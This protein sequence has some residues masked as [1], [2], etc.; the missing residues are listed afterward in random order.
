VSQQLQLLVGG[1]DLTPYVEQD[2]W[3]ITQQW[4]RQGD[5]ATFELTDEH[6]VHGALSFVPTP[7]TTVV[8]TDVGLGQTLFSGICEKPEVRFD[9]PTLARWTLDCVDWTYLSDRPS[10]LVVGDYSGYTADALAVLITTQANCG[11]NAATVANGGYV[12]PAVQIP[13]IQFVYDTLTVA[14][15]KL[16]KLASLSTTWGWYVDENRNLHF[17]DLTQAPSA[18]VTL[19]DSIGA[20]NNT[21]IVPYD[22]DSMTYEWDATSLRNVVTVRGADYSSS[23]TDLW[24][25]NGSQLSFPLTFVPDANNIATATL[26]VGGVAATV[27]ADTGSSASTDWIVQGNAANQWFLS[28]NQALTPPT[29]APA[30]ST[31]I[32]LA[33]PYLQPV[34]ARTQD[35]T[36]IAAFA[37]L[38][39]AGQFAYYIGDTSLP[40]LL[41]AV[42]RGQREVATYS[43]P[44]ERANLTIPE[45][46]TGHVRAGQLVTFVN[47]M[48]PDSRN[49]YASGVSDQFLILQNRITGAA[50]LYRTY[51]ITAVRV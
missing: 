40:T 4:S 26:T 39:N 25:G 42:Q 31:V 38:P 37:S 36:S 1:A 44:T 24:V 48:V 33:Y 28:A 13:R 20:V 21:T 18:G 49:G 46:F 30:T 51:G 6:P 41:S 2:A 29:A 34:V 27:S 16:S 5:T 45:T 32:S 12:W 22:N 17:Y 23:Q 35:S 10:N 7:L 15:T 50:G 9:G 11:I 43:L 8:L 47:A 3:S 19:T 14:W